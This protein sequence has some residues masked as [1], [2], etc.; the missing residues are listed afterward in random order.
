MKSNWDI[1]LRSTHN[2]AA[3]T[4]LAGSITFISNILKIYDFW[5]PDVFRPAPSGA[6]CEGSRVLASFL[7]DVWQCW[8]I[9]SG[10]LTLF[11]ILPQF[12]RTYH[13]ISGV[14]CGVVFI[15]TILRLSL[16]I[17]CG[18]VFMSLNL[19]PPILWFFIVDVAQFCF[20]RNGQLVLGAYDVWRLGA[21]CNH[22]LLKEC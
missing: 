9:S 8:Y 17:F 15:V 19:R 5:N 20:R 7:S 6:E 12:S 2:W 18:H 11:H 3:H 16:L 14:Y 22:R 1:F 10:R 4:S 21:A 13:D